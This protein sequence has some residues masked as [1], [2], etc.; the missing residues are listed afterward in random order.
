MWV[1]ALLV[2]FSLLYVLVVKF[3]FAIDQMHESALLSR[4]QLDVLMTMRQ[5][6][7]HVSYN[8]PFNDLRR[9]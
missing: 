8:S 7:E 4:T 6:H 9:L 5:S 3:V 2:L 1:V